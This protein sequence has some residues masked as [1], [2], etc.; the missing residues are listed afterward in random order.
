MQLRKAEQEATKS[1]NCLIHKN[2]IQS[3]PG[4]FSFLFFFFFFFSFLFFSFLF[5]SFL[6]FSFLFNFLCFLALTI[7]PL[8]KRWFQTKQEKEEAKKASAQASLGKEGEQP[9]S[10]RQQKK[11]MFFFFFFCYFSRLYC[12]GFPISLSFFFFYIHSFFYYY[13]LLDWKRERK[14]KKK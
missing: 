4:F 6:F 1:L 7:S 5:F 11:R 12:L 10:M 9:L 2:E 3:R 14:K 8:A 13:Q